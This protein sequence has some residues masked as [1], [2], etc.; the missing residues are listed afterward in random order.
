MTKMIY[1]FT[2]FQLFTT[3]KLH[4]T[5]MWCNWFDNLK[6]DDFNT[7]CSRFSDPDRSLNHKKERFK[8]FEVEPRLNQGRTVMTS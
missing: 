3:N 1:L 6:I 5:L 8:V 4:A 2:N 7:T